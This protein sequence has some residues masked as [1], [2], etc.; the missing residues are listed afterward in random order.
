M[1]KK[2]A[3]NIWSKDVVHEEPFGYRIAH[4]AYLLTLCPEK[5]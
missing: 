3:Q 2:D 4:Q 1:T 5:Y